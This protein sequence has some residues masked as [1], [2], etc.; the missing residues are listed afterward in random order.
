MGEFM[1]TEEEIR[2]ELKKLEK[3]KQNFAD[4]DDTGLIAEEESMVFE[5]YKGQI[6]VL[7][8]VLNEEE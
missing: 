8:W 5:Y 1:R 7:L 4:L 2:E 3:D 6:Q